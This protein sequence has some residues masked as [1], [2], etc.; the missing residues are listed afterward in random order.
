MSGGEYIDSNAKDEDH[1]SLQLNDELNAPLLL[2]DGMETP[3]FTQPCLYG[4]KGFRRPSIDAQSHKAK[5]KLITVTIICF[6]FMIAELIGG[7]LAGSLAIVAD[8]AHLLTDCISF[9]VAMFAM[10]FSKKPADNKMSFGYRRAEVLGAVLSVIGIWLLTGVLF[11]LAL[12][13][14]IKGDFDIDANTMIIVSI[15]GVFINIVMG[16][17]LHGSCSLLSHGHSHGLKTSGHN[18]SHN[19]SHNHA[20]NI[21][22][23]TLINNNHSH[24]NNSI[25][26]S[27]NNNNNAA[28]QIFLSPPDIMNNGGGGGRN[29]NLNRHN[30]FSSL[31]HNSSRNHSRHNSFTKNNNKI[32][33]ELHH[34]NHRA[35]IDLLRTRMDEPLIHRMS[36]DGGLTRVTIDNRSYSHNRLCDDVTNLQFAPIQHRTSVDSSHSSSGDSGRP[37]DD[38][39][40]NINLR[41]AVI[42]VIGDFIQSIGVLIAAVVIKMN[43]NA[44]IADPI[45]TFLFSI[46]VIFTTIRIMKDS[47]VVLLDAVPSNVVLNKLDTE[48]GC[49]Q[50]VRSVHH[51]NVWSVSVDW[52]I[53]SVH[54]IVDPNADTEE[55]LQAATTIA[56]KGFDI[57]HTTIQIER[58]AYLT[59][60]NTITT[61]VD[62]ENGNMIL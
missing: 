2:N 34:G 8:A 43:P 17:V 33:D 45:C 28:A 44:K 31:N 40:Q 20:A 39:K 51:L 13:R 52:N 19:H 32:N 38:P 53:M 21:N 37:T 25:S 23:N 7:Y 24:N 22:S 15:I 30:S 10:W 12:L 29:F 47:L 62:T 36:I 60:I 11:Y 50:G 46:I 35:S 6:I 61:L 48:L 3:Q 14:L 59:D 56:R 55:I 4:Q 54:L 41:A 49:I 1:F 18:H 5:R 26:N 58:S 42:H 27:L 57:K 9:I 16:I